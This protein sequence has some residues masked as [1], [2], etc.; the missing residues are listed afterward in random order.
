MAFVTLDLKKLESNFAYLDRLFKQNG[1]EWSVVTK[2]LSGNKTYLTEL[3][4]FD[5]HQVCDSRVSNLKEIRA[6]KP[7][8]ETVYIKP[9]AKRSIAN[10]VKYADISMNTE[11][12]TI[13]L[14]S[15]EAIRQNK[16]HKVIIMIELGELREGV[17]GEDLIDFYE[18]VFKLE[19][20]SVVGIGT[21]LSCMYGVLPNHDKLIQL[22][23]Y[24]QLIEAKFNKKIQYVSGGS[25]VTIPLITKRLLPKGVNHFR[26]GETLFLGTDVY[27]NSRFKKMNQDVFR[28]YSE[29]IELI[30][31]PV[32][33]M[34]EMG[35]NVEGDTFTFNESDIGEKSYRAIIDLGLL[36]VEK[37]NLEPVDKGLT[38][39]GA[40]SDMIVIDLDQN[41]K[42]YRV[43]DLVE[44]KLNYMGILRIL[45]SKYIEKKVVNGQG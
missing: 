13:K 22:S 23:L 38:L 45:N 9:P 43:G 41:S 5:I 32:V 18:S 6:I 37:D 20:I 44:F 1:I 27:N 16:I 25:S 30:E 7:N 15:K 24:K 11:I 4:K 35:T 33:P 29:I 31:K 8:I 17:L 19:N 3:L 12:E 28:L 42:K 36:D 26:V 40:S 34:G 14:L 39:A 10:V 21:N 2:I